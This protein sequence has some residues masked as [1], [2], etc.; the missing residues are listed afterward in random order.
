[1]LTRLFLLFVLVP[2][3]DLILLLLI[4]RFHWLISVVA[5]I[6]SGILGAWL[7]RRQGLAVASSLR[8]DVIDGRIPTSSLLDGGMV[9]LAAG[10]LLTPGLLTDLFGITFLVPAC[11]N[12]YK[13]RFKLWI[14]SRIGIKSGS[15]ATRAG[16]Q[17]VDGEFTKSKDDVDKSQIVDEIR[18]ES[19]TRTID[20]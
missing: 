14:Q 9:L 16:G 18:L 12:W 11:R 17:T 20:S 2:L 3:A 19:D 4:A 5:I 7:V 1:M 15:A 6:A 13:A 10:L 8:S